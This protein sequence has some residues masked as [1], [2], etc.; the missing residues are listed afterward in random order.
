MDAVHHR[1]SPFE[2]PSPKG[3]SND[4]VQP[5]SEGH[6]RRAVMRIVDIGFS[7][8]ALSS[9]LSCPVPSEHGNELATAL[10]QSRP[11]PLSRR[12]APT[13]ATLPVL[14]L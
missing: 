4:H 2:T 6:H 10:Q 11:R 14:C 12:A 9:F 1:S 3:V 5:S 7:P 13:E 8:S